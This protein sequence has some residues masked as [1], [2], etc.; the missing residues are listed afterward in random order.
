MHRHPFGGM[1]ARM[2]M[3]PLVRVETCCAPPF[4]K[5][6]SEGKKVQIQ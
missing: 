6:A 4:L 5:G 3:D 1:A 2:K